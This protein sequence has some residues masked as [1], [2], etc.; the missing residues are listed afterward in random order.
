MRREDYRATLTLMLGLAAA[1]LTGFLREA[2]LADQLGVGRATDIYLIA[3]TIPEF[4]FIALPIVLTPAFLPLF[5]Q[6]RL[7]AGE[8]AA[9]RFARRVAGAVLG[10]LL[11]LTLLL[12]AAAPRFLPWLAPGFGPLERALAGRGSAPTPNRPLY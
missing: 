10:V 12:A 2:A 9:W 8:G 4:V 7:R 6:L 3:F 5:A 1:T 11:L